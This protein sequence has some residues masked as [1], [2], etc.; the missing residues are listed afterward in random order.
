MNILNKI[1]SGGVR[2]GRYA[3]MCTSGFSSIREEKWGGCGRAIW[4]RI[5]GKLQVN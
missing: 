4:S 3:E 1:G 5:V 2:R